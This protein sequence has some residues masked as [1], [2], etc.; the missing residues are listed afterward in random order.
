MDKSSLKSGYIA[1]SAF[2][3]IMF[4][5]QLGNGTDTLMRRTALPIAILVRLHFIER[6]VLAD[7]PVHTPAGAYKDAGNQSCVA[8]THCQFGRW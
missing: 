3:R 1:N 8:K 6:G 2:H 7:G 5:G 4:L